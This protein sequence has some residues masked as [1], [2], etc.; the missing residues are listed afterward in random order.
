MMIVSGTPQLRQLSHHSVRSQKITELYPVSLSESRLVCDFLKRMA[1]SLDHILAC[2][3][4][5]EDFE[6]SGNTCQH[7]TVHATR[8]V[9]D[10]CG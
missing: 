7:F 3:I 6:E 5:L 9:S 10:V 8:C 4:C 1:D 2:Q